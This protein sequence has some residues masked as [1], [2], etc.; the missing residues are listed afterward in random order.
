MNLVF[1]RLSQLRTRDKV[2]FCGTTD[3]GV[4]RVTFVCVK[5]D[6]INLSIYVGKRWGIETTPDFNEVIVRKK[7][8]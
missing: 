3:D 7:T 4:P 5:L 1:L 8:P 2:Y 6:G